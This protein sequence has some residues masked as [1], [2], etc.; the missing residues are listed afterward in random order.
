MRLK[1]QVEF[2]QAFQSKLEAGTKL[3]I[4]PHLRAD[5]DAICSSLALKIAL[6]KIGYQ[7]EVYLDEEPSSYYD[8]LP[9]LDLLNVFDPEAEDVEFSASVTLDCHGPDRLENR[10]TLWHSAPLRFIIDHHQMENEP[11]E[12]FYWVESNRSSTCE[13]IYLLIKQMEHDLNIEIMDERIAYYIV[14]GIYADTGGMRYSNTSSGTFKILAEL[15]KWDVP[16]AHISEKLFATISVEEFR[17][18]GMAFTK[19][20][21]ECDGRLAW[22]FFQKRELYA[23]GVSS[24]LL[25]AFSS[26]LRD[27]KGV[28]LSIFMLEEENEDGSLELSLSLRSSEDF[29]AL[30]VAKALGGG[31]H[32]RAAGATVAI[33]E[34]IYETV[35]EVLQV[36]RKALIGELEN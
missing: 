1:D 29:A 26:L 22:C 27:V 3:I 9:G 36:A 24:D 21:F 16:I 13:L 15:M 17:A 25:G 31:G 2:W 19:T 10:A 32:I 28:D 14:T 23:C 8:F 11:G 30:P 34:D 6:E 4:A 33:K 18:R 5:S 35:E 20:R 12:G 7:V